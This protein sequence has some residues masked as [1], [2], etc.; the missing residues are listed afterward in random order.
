[1]TDLQTGKPAARGS[2]NYNGSRVVDGIYMAQ[3]QGSI[4]AMVDDVDAMVNNPRKGHENDQVWEVRSN[5]VPK[6]N[7]K[8]MVR[9]RL[10]AGR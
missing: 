8:V 6:L 1:V 2:W 10:E 5:A 3:Q 7:T 4:V 9:F